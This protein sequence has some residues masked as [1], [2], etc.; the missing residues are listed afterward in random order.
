MVPSSI[1]PDIRGVQ[2]FKMAACK[3]E[4][5]TS[6]L[7]DEIQPRLKGQSTILK[8]RQ[9]LKSWFYLVYKLRYNSFRF[10]GRNLE[11]LD[12]LISGT[13]DVGTIE[14][15]DSENVG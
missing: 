9:P 5:V 7:V 1:V 2:T 4:V 14:L 15:L 13:M 11:F 3:P 10:A 12:S 8:V 6:Q